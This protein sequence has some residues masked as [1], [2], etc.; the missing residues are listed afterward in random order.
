MIPSSR[1]GLPSAWNHF[2]TTALAIALATPAVVPIAAN[3]QAAGNGS[4][5][6]K[7]V[8]EHGAVI[9]SAQV[10]VDRTA[11]GALSR[12]DGTYILE[13][14]PA[15]SH[16]IR[17]RLIGF[18]PDSATVSVSAGQRATQDFTL[19]SDPLQ[20]QSVVVTGTATPTVN[21]KSSVSITSMTP[22]EIQQSAPRS[23]TEMLRYVPGFT[24][25]ESSGGEVNE[26]ISMRGILGVEYVM[27]MEDG[28]PVFPT[29]HTFFMNADNLFRPDENIERMEVVRGGS[30]AL[31]G[32]NTPGAIINFINKTGGDQ[33]QGT[34]VATGGTQGLARYDV[35]VNGPLSDQWR[36]NVGGFY[37]YDHGVRDPGFPGIRGG[38]LK[39]NVTRLL[40]NG[41]IRFSA[42]VIDD[43]NQFILDLPFEG[44]GNP[45]FVPGFGTY[46]SM[47]TN[48][49]LDLTVPTPTGRQEFPL[50]NGIATNAS[51]FTAD[52]AF[53]LAN[54]WHLRN[55]AQI[56]RDHEEWNAL[57]PSNAM[58]VQDFLT[59]PKGQGGLG[60]PAGSNI[61][62]TYTNHF[63]DFGNPLPF[64]TPND[65]V[66]PG[67]DIHVA[68]PIAA[69]QDQ[70]QLRKTFNDKNSISFGAYFANYSQDNH[71]FISQVLTDVRN[72]PRFLD[73]VV[74]TP[75]GS[76]TPITQNGF[77]NFMSGYT[78]GTG[79][80]SIFSGVVGADLQLTDQLR[81]DV[82]GRVEYDDYVQASENTGSFDLDSN[83]ATPFNNETFGNGTFRHFQRGITD[84]AASLGLNYAL[85]DNLS[86]YGSLARGY[87][88]P[89]LDE[90][91]QA[92]AQQ[93]V[94]LFKSKEVQSYEAGVKGVAGPLGF[95]V[96]GFYT[97][98][99]NVV[100]Q[101]LV[102]DSVT[103]ASTW[104]IQPQPQNKSYGAEVELLAT[105]IEGLQLLGSG[106][107]LRAE[108]GTGAGAQVGARLNG[109]PAS[110]GNVSGTYTLGRFRGLADWHWVG[111]RFVDI[112][113]GTA[114]PAYSYF[115][116]GVSYLF[117]A[118]GVTLDVRLLNAFQGEGLEEG[119]PRL[120][121]SGTS[122][123]FLA[124]PILPRRLTIALRYDFGAGGASTASD[125]T[126]LE[127][128]QSQS[129][130]KSQ[131]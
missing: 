91:L 37:R 111:S 104:V 31:F 70:L 16:L 83:A 11:I 108:L 99:K 103:G 47:N 102:I 41:Y 17:V 66:A 129:P 69:F 21:L 4:V 44:N 1:M 24:R 63:D 124:R 115:N 68:K 3:A 77:M 59:G 86:L 49:G 32:S 50:G 29:M 30:S 75:G 65:L 40:D 46:G 97:V 71:W 5:A 35:D 87:K 92:T 7:I 9:N 98:L 28:L 84:W 118:N 120:L 113:T 85:K 64:N 82:G 123:I 18:R 90:F 126:T 60:L 55:G 22:E 79:Q 57:V 8:D 45:H 81:A 106:T 105:P 107:L 61:Q 26:N 119:N 39:A 114:L 116:F 94:N 62:L 117:P 95:A 54:N 96:D 23:T 121:T 15:G 80:T 110:L 19:H 25:V 128:S 33:L 78:N 101:G 73:A 72:N 130:S 14:V 43:N 125:S 100:N 53:D 13:N 88:M 48:E 131:R 127:T 42:K 52:A 56:M 2:A 38:Q 6:G 36:F 34:M 12:G 27:F 122:S 76:P 112:T 74:T 51:W 58:T 20:L 89:A 67:Q 109:V 93:Q 10:F